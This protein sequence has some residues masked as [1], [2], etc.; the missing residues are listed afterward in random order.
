MTG[1]ASAL[2]VGKI[3]PEPGVGGIFIQIDEG[4]AQLHTFNAEAGGGPV[5]VIIERLPRVFA[6]V[7]CIAFQGACP[8]IVGGVLF[9]RGAINQVVT[10]LKNLQT[11]AAAYRAAGLLQVF[12]GDLE[13]GCTVWAAGFVLGG[14]GFRLIVIGDETLGAARTRL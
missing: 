5:I 7:A 3:F 11:G 14:H 4:V 13:L 12:F 8:A 2:H 6:G 9:G 10:G 1:A